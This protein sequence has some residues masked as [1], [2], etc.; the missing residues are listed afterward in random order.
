M[1]GF[2][3]EVEKLYVAFK[4]DLGPFQGFVLLS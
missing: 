2:D 4:E 1:V 3:P